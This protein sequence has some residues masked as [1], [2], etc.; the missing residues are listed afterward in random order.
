[1]LSIAVCIW[2]TQRNARDNHSLYRQ[3]S[4]GRFSKML[5]QVLSNLPADHHLCADIKDIGTRSNRKGAG[6]YVLALCEMFAV[7]G[8]L[9]AGKFACLVRSLYFI[10]TYY[11]RMVAWEC[12][13]SLHLWDQALNILLDE[14][15]VACQNSFAILPPHFSIKIINK[16]VE[17][18][19][20]KILSGD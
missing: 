20:T 6:T 7:Q 16:I 19:W 17:L 13:R 9:R 12:S 14:L 11:L 15:C 8:Y 2:C 1:M 3:K 10:F 4:Q 5:R 18:G